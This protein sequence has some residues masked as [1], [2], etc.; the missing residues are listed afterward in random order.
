MNDLVAFLRARLDEDE[1]TA[2]YA[3]PARVAWLT[4]RNDAGQ[5]YYTTVAAGGEGDWDVWAADGKELPEPDSVLVVYDPA[6]ALR[7]VE[8]KRAIL[9]LHEGASGRL[10]AEQDDFDAWVRG[11]ATGPRPKST[12][13][14]PKLI[15]GLECA[16]RLLGAVYSGHPD[17]RPG[18]SPD[19]QAAPVQ[20]T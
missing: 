13:P 4:Y 20:N 15:A 11:A 7:E 2:H 16:I 9:A 17:Y 14:H 12:G 18:W 1:A 6:R 10:H 3:G 8:A 5:L 19:G